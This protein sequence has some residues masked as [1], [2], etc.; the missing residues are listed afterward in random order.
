[1][2]MT[3]SKV[4]DDEDNNNNDDDDEVDDNDDNVNQNLVTKSLQE[5]QLVLLQLK[6]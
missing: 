3:L 5:D 2:M 6:G 4:V 1:M